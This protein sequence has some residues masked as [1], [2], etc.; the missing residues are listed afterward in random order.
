LI[1]GSPSPGM[2]KVW[3]LKRTQSRRFLSTNM[4]IKSTVTT[5]RGTFT[6]SSL[7]PRIH[8]RRSPSIL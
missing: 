3:T 5:L 1:N 4:A 2:P 7:T 8:R 6:H